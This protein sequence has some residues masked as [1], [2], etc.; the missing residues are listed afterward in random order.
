MIITVFSKQRAII[1]MEIPQGSCLGPLLLLVNINGIFYC[2]CV[3]L[4]LFA[5]DDLLICNYDAD[6]L[7]LLYLKIQQ[8]YG[9][10]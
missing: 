6:I 3:K 7:F 1:N 10:L 9:K 4:R 2:T 8:F 5:N